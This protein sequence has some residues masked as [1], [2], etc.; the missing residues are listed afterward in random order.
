M[1]TTDDITYKDDFNINNVEEKNYLRI[2]FNG[3]RSVQV[4]ELNQL[5]S[6]LQSQIDKF[7][8]SIWKNGTAVIGGGC[9]FDRKINF[10]SFETANLNDENIDASKIGK[11]IQGVLIANVLGYRADENITTFFIKYSSGNN[12]DNTESAFDLQE[13]INLVPSELGNASGSFLSADDGL[14]AGAFLSEGVIFVN[15]SFVI[16]PKQSIFIDLPQD[17]VTGSVVL[18]IV[19]SHV[20]YIDDATLLDN[21]QGKP[22]HLAPGADR[23]QIKLNLAFL[24]SDAEA[25][26][27][28][29]ITLLDVVDSNVVINTKVRYTDLDRQL[30]QRTEEESGSYVINPFKISIT[31]LTNSFRPGSLETNADEN[32]Y[33]GLDP[34]IAYV[35]GYRIELSKKLDLTIPKARTTRER[36]VNV[37]LNYGNYID[38]SVQPGSSMPLPSTASLIYELLN[39]TGVKIGETRIKAIE[40]NGS[41]FRIFLYDINLGPFNLSDIAKI[42]NTNVGVNLNARSTVTNTAS[43]TSVFKLPFNNIRS[44]SH[45]SADDFNYIVKKAF[46][47]LT[48]AAGA[49]VINTGENETFEDTSKANFSVEA[50]G[51]WLSA[52]EFNVTSSSSSSATVLTNPSVGNNVPIRVLVP[53]KT[54][55]NTPA[56]KSLAKI[57]NEVL[58]PDGNT[59]TLT[60]SDI[61]DISSVLINGTTT[62]ISNSI[63]LSSNGQKST[64]YVNGTLQYT[65]AG[66]APT[67]RVS[68][69]YFQHNG[70]PFTANSYPIDW[71][72]SSVLA[73]DKIRYSDMPSFNGYL[74]SDCVDFRPLILNGGGLV[75]ISHPDPNSQLYCKPTFFLPRYDKIIVNANGEFSIINGNPSL[76][77]IAPATPPNALCLYELAIPA[78]TLSPSDVIVSLIDNRRYTMRDIG[79]I[80]KRLK[81]LEYYTSLSLLE[82][83]ISERSIFDDVQGQRFKNGILVDPFVGHNIGNV[84]IPEYQ[85]SIDNMAGILR[86]KFNMSSLDLVLDMTEAERNATNIS[87]NENTITLS[88]TEAPLISQ[89]RSSESESVNPYDVAAFIGTMK[90][91]PTND[92]WMETNRRPTV[93]INNDGVYDAL[94][95]SI[96]ESGILGTQWNSWETNWS[97]TT[98]SV[99]APHSVRAPDGVFRQSITTRTVSEQTRTGTLTT[100]T[101]QSTQENLGDKVVDIS[102][103]PFIRSRKVYFEVKGLKPNTKVYPFFDGINVSEYCAETDAV[104]KSSELTSIVEYF[105]K[106]PNDDGFIVSTDLISDAFGELIGEFIIPNNS[107]LKFSTGERVFK[108]SDSITNNTAEETTFAEGFYNASG[109]TQSVENTILSTRFPIISQ[110]AVSDARVQVDV[111]VRYVDP[112]AQTFLI[113]SIKEGVFITSLDLFFVARSS[114]STPVNVRLVAVDNGFPTQR[115]IP[116]SETSLRSEEVNIDGS[117]TNFKFSDPVFIKSGVEYA[118]VVLSNDPDYRLRVSRLGGIDENGKTIQSNP[119]AGVMFTSQNAST[120]TPDQTRDLKFQLNRAVFDTST[121]GAVSFKS[122]MREGVESITISNPGTNYA[123]ATISIQAPPVATPPNI[124]ATAT[125]VIDF[126]TG[127]ITGA[128]ITNPGTGYVTAPLVTIARVGGDPGTEAIGTANL[129]GAAISE[130]SLF[131]NNIIHENTFLRNNVVING[132]SYQDV[133]SKTNYKAASEYNV[134]RTNEIAL[135]TL[136]ASAS[137]FISPIIDLDTMSF[138]AIENKINN[139]NNNEDIKVGGDAIARYI[140]R[141]VE[142]NDP[143]DQLNIYADINRPSDTVEVSMYVRLKYDSNTYSDWIIV[144]PL[145]KIPISASD[146]IFNEVGYVHNSIENDF[147]AFSIK[148]VMTSP[149]STLIPYIKNLRII[150]TS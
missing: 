100:L 51:E 87:V 136:I 144:N 5:Q 6:I 94:K 35:D 141:E 21:F 114:S 99:S 102:F 57:Q 30:A 33:V 75:N 2:L 128:K 56:T 52:D 109:Q 110:T 76:E 63:V 64:M 90:L 132:D 67:I 46:S 149:S 81:N 20:T 111:N 40:S 134:N 48:N 104:I 92:Q 54:R 105:D 27:V 101:T 96:E 124:R 148:I 126:V 145:N 103:I 106:K 16:T 9:T 121:I 146:L 139:S 147:V 59:Y 125:P 32:L 45:V 137:E 70:L 130:F 28:N 142:L 82:K 60:K 34:S 17:T 119:Y 108:L 37:S 74:L 62:D 86:P 122:I 44:L 77:P 138:L 78:Y 117:A 19:E 113:N 31:E 80:D 14:V 88:F 18:E 84:F 93:I 118:I 7:G 49:F 24:N 133:I 85:C 95:F 71:D 50:G 58:S 26:Q 12:A 131:Q 66:A 15:G 13:S 22:N 150:A 69:R 115:I 55:S 83:S 65:G 112:L 47:G 107:V 120:W 39:S 68:Y 29:R 79:K 36:G 98:T 140:T 11:L 3:S 91:F 127:T 89:L 97:G 23:Y 41:L 61:F 42:V 4:R 135:N 10:I 116:F 123:G 72:S 53:V 43:D 143:A 8:S 38:V 1:I 25:D 73:D 129:H